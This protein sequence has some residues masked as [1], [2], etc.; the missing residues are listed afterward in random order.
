MGCRL[1]SQRPLPE[2]PFPD[3]LLTP[4]RAILVAETALAYSD[5]ATRAE[6][7]SGIR[8]LLNNDGITARRESNEDLIEGP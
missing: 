4:D 1:V 3:V 2:L 5:Y 7:G 6:G 8:P